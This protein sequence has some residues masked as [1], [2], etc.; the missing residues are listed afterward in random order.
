MQ[1]LDGVANEVGAFTT[2]AH[3]LI[4]MIQNN[5]VV[6]GLRDAGYKIINFPSGYEYTEG[7]KADHQIKKGVY[8]DNFSQ[9]LIWNSVAYPFV[10]TQLYN[11][12]RNTI[13]NSISGL[14]ELAD[15]QSPRLVIA[16]I[17]AP[18]PPFVFD[19]AGNPITPPYAFTAI[20]AD[21]LIQ[22][23]SLDYYKTHYPD[24]LEFVSKSVLESIRA[25]IKN[26][27]IQP[28]IILS[29]D[30]GPALTVSLTDVTSSSQYER[31]HI[32]NALY[33]PEFDYSQISSDHTPVNTFRII[34]NE[35]FGDDMESLENR[36][37]S[38]SHDHPY[39]FMEVE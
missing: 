25:I 11:W 2:D 5:M 35:Y 4:E 28:I 39:Q 30:H 38:S 29:G 16:H 14:S 32:L 23:T 9:T 8:L 19:E 37:Y 24:Q 22:N 17:F 36:S 13:V 20:D 31:M 3:P 10:H 1:H 21:T 34:F 12:H 26:S 6:N 33:L 7:I 27:E 18:H 15:Y